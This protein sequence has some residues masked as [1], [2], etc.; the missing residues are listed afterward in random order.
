MN[1]NKPGRPRVENP[2]KKEKVDL[3]LP[4][5]MRE[6]LQECAD[7]DGR[8][9]NQQIVHYIEAGINGI[10]ATTLAQAVLDIRARFS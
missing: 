8:S 9:M 3:R 4:E 5:G 7:R 6:R 2:T 1:Q 10:D